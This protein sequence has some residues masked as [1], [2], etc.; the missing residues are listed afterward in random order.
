MTT[1]R[2]QE[3]PTAH[4]I[5]ERLKAAGIA[6]AAIIDDVY[7]PLRCDDLKS[8]I[9]DFWNAIERDK[10]RLAELS[11]VAAGIS[12]QADI[13]DEVLGK[14]WEK[15]S[16]LPKLG[17]PLAEQLFAKRLSDLAPLEE[18]A[19]HL[20]EAGVEPVPLGREDALPGPFKLVF[21]DWILGSEPDASRISE[22]RARK[23]YTEHDAVAD[24]PFIILMSSKPVEAAAAKDHFRSASSLLGGLFGFVAKAE[25]KDRTQLFMYLTAWSLDLPARHDI[26]YFVEALQAGLKGAEEEFVRRIRSLSFED[27]ANI[28]SLSLHA[29]GH[30]LG[31]YMLWL[32]K[33]LL[34]HL[35]HDQP[36]VRE[37]QKR[38]DAMSYKQFVPV[39][40]HPSSELAEIYQY[41][42]TEPAV[43]EL[44]PHPRASEGSKEPYLQ[45]GDL[46]FKESGGH[47][48]IMVANAA[49]D[50]AYSPG[51]ARAFRADQPILLLQGTLQRYEEVDNSKDVRTELVKHEN[52]PYRILWNTGH[53]TSCEYGKVAEWFRER[54]YKRK[55]RLALPYALEVQQAFAVRMTR[56]GMP[57]RPP[58]CRR[59]DVEVY[60]KGDG[61]KCERAGEVITDGAIVFQGRS[62]DGRD[63]EQFVITLTCVKAVVGR[64][65]GATAGC[66]KE[67]AACDAA[68][69]AAGSEPKALEKAKGKLTGAVNK[70]DK[71][72]RLSDP[73]LE[74]LA[75]ARRPVAVPP[76]NS[77]TAALVHKELLSVYHNRTFQ[78]DYKFN[79]P[80]VLNLIVKDHAAVAASEGVPPAECRAE[81]S[82]EALG[83]DEL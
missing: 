42:L 82:I 39:E 81:V 26:Q 30:P 13:T 60:F 73:S 67:K 57:V 70:L 18:L 55:L 16:A 79:L 46:F 45:L 23:L 35:F 76:A 3:E 54:K 22:E 49:C 50:L 48:V 78:G 77:D 65:S 44:G 24:K 20:K 75:A 10:E 56:V 64:L 15:R 5:V 63:E 34:T 41:A 59:A 2:A 38:L 53:V 74:W 21:L 72:S 71:L 32:Y 29:E 83:P 27:Y 6:K 52:R 80:I 12:D 31:D 25:I 40:E 37:Q 47:E 8:E 17:A 4:P 33:A 68:V 43:E 7:D 62:A 58:I 69:T 14:L 1:V 36:R 51:E 11:T 61:G 66:E 19:R 28:Q 9:S